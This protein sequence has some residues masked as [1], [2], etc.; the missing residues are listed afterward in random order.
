[1]VMYDET[2]IKFKPSSA[3]MRRL[4]QGFE[5]KDSI[6]NIDSFFDSPDFSWLKRNT[7]L[8]R[9]NGVYQMKT[10]DKGDVRENK[11]FTDDDLHRVFGVESQQELLQYIEEN[12]QNY[13]T[14]KTERQRWESE[15][16]GLE[17]VVDHVT[18]S[19]YEDRFAELEV[20]NDNGKKN[21]ET[22]IERTDLTILQN[23]KIL[24]Y[25]EEKRPNLYKD[26]T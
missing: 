3:P 13:A 20:I 11:E 9:R 12:F 24:I 23:P 14:L 15:E 8:R 17:L 10:F 4:K 18:A 2:E 22:I 19:G 1:M 7:Y 21:L 16:E 26:I 25:L 5:P 6:V